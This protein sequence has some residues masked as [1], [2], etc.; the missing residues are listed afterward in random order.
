MKKKTNM[1]DVV[2]SSMTLGV[3]AVALGAMGQGALA[4]QIITPAANMYG[5]TVTAGMGMDVLNMVN[6]GSKK[7]QKKGGKKW[8]I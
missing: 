8:E 6:E 7:L 3:G 5:T 4:G 2:K 1:K